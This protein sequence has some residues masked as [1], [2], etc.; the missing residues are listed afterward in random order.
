M[1]RRMCKDSELPSRSTSVL[2]GRGDFWGGQEPQVL[3]EAW[4]LTLVLPLT[5]I[6]I[7]GKFL[8]FQSGLFHLE[9]QGESSSRRLLGLGVIISAEKQLVT[10]DSLRTHPCSGRMSLSLSMKESLWYFQRQE[11]RIQ[12][13]IAGSS[14]RPSNST[15]FS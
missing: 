4:N 9:S 7:W 5:D 3:R 11:R 12:L 14:A 6:V 10:G 8:I 15:T 13:F 2:L 1:F